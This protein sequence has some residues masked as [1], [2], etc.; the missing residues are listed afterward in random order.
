[1]AEKFKVPVEKGKTY[2]IDIVRLGAGGEGVGRRGPA[3]R[4]RD[5]THYV[6]KKAVCRRP[7]GAHTEG[8][9]SSREAFLSGLCRLRRLSVAAPFL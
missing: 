7:A 8:F 4:N 1:M 6:R 5:G 2:T 9:T 3:E